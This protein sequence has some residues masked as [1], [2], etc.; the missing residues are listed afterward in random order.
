MTRSGRDHAG[1]TI[2]VGQTTSQPVYMYAG[3]QPLSQEQ[4]ELIGLVPIES[5]GPASRGHTCSADSCDCES[6]E[7]EL[8]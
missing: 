1:K 6:A 5:A 7:T 4:L 2:S 8:A 3:P